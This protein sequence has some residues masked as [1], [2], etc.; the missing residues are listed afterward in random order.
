MATKKTKKKAAKKPARVARRKV[1]KKKSP[2]TAPK[3]HR[4][5]PIP[6]PVSETTTIEDDDRDDNLHETDDIIA[7]VDVDIER[8]GR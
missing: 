3:K 5:S 8:S 1:A 2:H 4:R 7:D 6:R